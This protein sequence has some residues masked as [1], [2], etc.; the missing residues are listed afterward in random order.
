MA[1]EASEKFEAKYTV[2]E[3]DIL[4]GSVK[5]EATA[6]GDNDSDEPTDPGDDET[7]DPT[8]EPKPSLK[9][10]KTTTSTPA[11]GETYALGEE[12]TYEITVTNDG[13]L[14]IKNVEVKDE[15]TNDTWTIESLAPE[16]SEKFEAKYTVTEADILAGSVKNEATA[17]GDNDSD[18]PTDPG[19]DD[20]DDP[21]EEKN[22]HMTIEKVTTSKPNDAKGYV[23]GEDITYEITVLNDGNV[24]ISDITVNDDL[25]GDKWTIE[26]LAPNESMVFETKYTVTI[27]DQIAG[28]VL[29]VATATG[30]DPEGDEPEIVPGEDPE[31]TKKS[32]LLTVLYY[33][34]GVLVEDMTFTKRYNDG[35]KYDVASPAVEGFT[36]TA[37]RVT[38]TITA[39]TTREVYY[40]RN[41]YR[42]TV[43][44]R[45]WETGVAVRP[46]ITQTHAYGDNYRVVS[47]TLDGYKCSRTVVS[48][49][50]PA[51]D[52]QVT[53]WYTPAE[54]VIDEY[55]TP[56]GLDNVSL[57][58]GEC[59]E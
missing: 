33:V 55:G 47:P 21:T 32:F 58:M 20:T 6:D 2:T 36:P 51:Y 50:M 12:I 5:N 42:L 15:L 24:T 40:T 31:P 8:E 25:T 44:Y 54:T 27:E 30:I 37:A 4:A 13:N 19:D 52:V 59:I 48:G 23:A 41:S 26:S 38:G 56:L 39:D 35:D 28:E 57:N 46:S 18:E 29:N 22:P 9:V 10:E 49:T 53:V 7:E 45:Y 14:T 3:A 17:D 11:N 16:A 43:Y 1:P 34:D